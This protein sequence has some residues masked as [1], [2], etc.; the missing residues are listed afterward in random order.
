MWEKASL[1]EYCG[2]LQFLSNCL[3]EYYGRNVII[4]ID[5]YDVPLENAYL[6]G[7]Y[8]QMMDFIRSFFEAAPKDQQQ[9]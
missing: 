2:S 3:Q 5:E 7:F 6:R 8:Q 1:D 4:L 9:P